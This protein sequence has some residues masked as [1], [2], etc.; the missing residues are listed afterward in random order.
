MKRLYF[1]ILFFTINR[2]HGFSQSVLFEKSFEP[3]FNSGINKVIHDSSENFYAIG[4]T[5]DIDY[6]PGGMLFKFDP[7][8]QFIYKKY[9]HYVEE[10]F[11]NDIII[12][13]D[14]NLLLC[15]CGMPCDYLTG[16]SGI[17]AKVNLNGN[18]LWR[19]YINPDTMTIWP[20]H[21]NCLSHVIE[22]NDGSF[23]ATA[24]STIYRCHA[25]GDTLYT[26]HIHGTFHSLSVGRNNTFL[27]GTS[28]S[29]L[30][31]DGMSQQLNQRNFGS[32]VS[33]VKLLPDS[34]YLILSGDTLFKLDAML[35]TTN[36]YPLATIQLYNT[37]VQLDGNKI[38]ISNY[39]GSDFASFDYNLQLIDSF[40]TQQAE[41]AISSLTISDSIICVAGAENGHKNYCYLKSYTTSGSGYFNLVDLALT[42]ISFDTA[43]FY[44]PPNLPTGVYELLFVARIT[45]Q[46]NGTDTIHHFNINAQSIL[47]NVCGPVYYFLA[48]DSINLVPGQL[49]SIPLDTLDE[50][51]IGPISIFPFT[52]RFCAWLSCPDSLVDKN[53]SN[54]YLCDSVSVDRPDHVD[55]LVYVDQI[56]IYP[57]PVINELT[58]EFS[59]KIL[60]PVQFELYNLLGEK[61]ASGE[62]SEK[63]NRVDFSKIS[64]G[65][66]FIRILAREHN[67]KQKIIKL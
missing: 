59:E 6:G 41:V 31:F 34:S 40:R 32:P 51:G 19:S 52:Y 56:A 15:G 46:N 67:S 7:S 3:L 63:K 1:L 36:N 11:L 17:L 66:Y 50:Y 45:V 16:K 54:D 12:T 42:D 44:H 21:D 35:N 48:V 27:A 10:D 5:H 2:L 38:W 13:S 23:I 14:T 55:E 64:S 43:Y 60:S 39:E 47:P 9:F 28:L 4:S 62:M 20:D 53:H 65:L 30:Q 57:V 33:F 24:D 29:L 61:I 26:K 22:W 25:N 49:M 18:E 58:V 8:G 37:R